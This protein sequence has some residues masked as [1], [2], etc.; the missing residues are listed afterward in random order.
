MIE[1][2]FT[3]FIDKLKKNYKDIIIFFIPIIIAIV[4]L[5]PVDYYITIGGGII[6]IDESIIVDK[7]SKDIGSFNSA[8]VSQLKGNIATYLLSFVIDDFE[9]EKIEDIVINEESIEDYK[10][11]EEMMFNS[12]ISNALYVAYSNAG[13]KIVLKENKLKVMY[14]DSSANTTLKVKDE[15]IKF[16]GV[17]VKDFSSIKNIISSKKVG[18]VIDIVVIRDKKEELV[19]ALVYDVGGENKI[20]VGIINDTVYDVDPNVDF[21][22]SGKEAGSSGGL[23]MS[24]SIYNKLVD[25]DITKG[26]KIVG[27]G[28]ID[29]DGVVG[30]IG[31]VKYK[32]QGAVKANADVFL[33]PDANYEEAKNIADEKDYDIKLIKVSSF[34]DA[35]NKLNQLS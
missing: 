15:I 10:Y 13:K 2:I 1:K 25:E 18:D 12:S 21:N 22:F 32:L 9:K 3:T 23:I 24:L 26:Y 30:E 4:L 29:V 17:F 31:G 8:Y 5:T 7:E 6:S 35:I 28:T 20:G 33:V 14:I 19:N 11:R 16:D 34:D 27:T